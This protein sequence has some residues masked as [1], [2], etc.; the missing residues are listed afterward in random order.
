LQLPCVYENL[1]CHPD[2]PEARYILGSG[3]SADSRAEAEEQARFTVMRQVQSSLKGEIDRFLEAT[4]IDG[5]ESV[6]QR[7]AISISA[8]SDFEHGEMIRI[9]PE[10][11]AYSPQRWYAFAVL[12]RNRIL[13]ALAEEYRLEAI[14]FRRAAAS[15]LV[16]HS[17][18]S[19]FTAAYRK[20]EDSFV[21]LAAKA[22]E[23]R[24]VV[25]RYHEPFTQD[26]AQFRRVA[27][28]RETVLMSLGIA[29][30]IEAAEGISREAVSNAVIG[31]LSSMGLATNIGGC[32]DRRYQLHFRPRLQWEKAKVTRFQ[33]SLALS[34]RLIDCRSG[35]VLTELDIVSQD[36]NG[37]GNTRESALRNLHSR[38]A[39]NLSPSL[40]KDLQAVLPL[41]KE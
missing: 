39:V 32:S 10:L 28:M 4:S 41:Q 3:M 33:C 21:D 26:L 1:S 30:H 14:P 31:A 34:G 8:A 18:L 22:Y 11:C 20:T 19:A 29:V 15:A 37:V 17:D 9:V 38:L 35:E 13:T 6:R 2:Y 23:I 36:L 27:E 5:N 40:R 7:I 24:A 16:M 25:G 12:S